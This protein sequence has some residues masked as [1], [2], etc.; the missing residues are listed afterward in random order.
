MIIHR[1]LPMSHI[2]LRLKPGN[3]LKKE[4]LNYAKAQNLRAAV[5]VSALGSLSK[6][7]LRFA[8]ANH[9]TLLVESFEILTLTGFFS[10]DEGHFHI[11]ISNS[12]GNVL[13]GHLLDGS[14]IYTTAEILILSL[15][16]TEFKR[17]F[18]SSSGF[19]ELVVS[20]IK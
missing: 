3:D 17:E 11:S 13:G 15:A 9:P 4:L 12:S 14:I 8:N 5:V 10:G 7:S 20:Q 19:K 6:A 2:V 1:R 16:N 18:D